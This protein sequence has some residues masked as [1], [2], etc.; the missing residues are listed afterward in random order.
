MVPISF[1]PV[2]TVSLDPVIIQARLANFEVGKIYLDNGSSTYIIYEHCFNKLLQRVKDLKRPPL[3]P[4]VGFNCESSC[5]IGEVSMEVM[6]SEYPLHRIEVVDFTIVRAPLPYNVLLGR[7]FMQKFRV[8]T[9]TIHGMV[10]FPTPAGVATIKGRMV[11]PRESKHVNKE[12]PKEVKHD[13]SIEVAS[14]P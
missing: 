5:P 1:P 2:E 13:L 11:W 4:L 9:S 7:P 10:K 14:L 3:A 8:I 6:M 12:S